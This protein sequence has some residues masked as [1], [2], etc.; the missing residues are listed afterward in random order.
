MGLDYLSAR[1]LDAKPFISYVKKENNN[2]IYTSIF[3][4]VFYCLKPDG[5]YERNF[6]YS[7]ENF[8]CLNKEFALTDYIIKDEA[9]FCLETEEIFYEDEFYKCTYN[10]LK[11][12]NTFLV[13]E[14]GTKI[15]VKEALQNN[16][17]PIEDLIMQGIPCI[18]K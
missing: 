15:S 17:E 10:C 6:K 13:Y 2:K 4:K 11:S 14:D 5:S 16:I 1:F 8:A 18:K 12:E 7:N 3:Y 9:I